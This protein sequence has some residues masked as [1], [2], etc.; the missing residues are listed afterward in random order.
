MRRQ[1]TRP[2]PHVEYVVAGA[3]PGKCREDLR[4]RLGVPAHEARVGIRR[5]EKTHQQMVCRRLLQ[6]LPVEVELHHFSG[7]DE[8][9]DRR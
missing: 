1:R 5:D 2:T 3:H 7:T 6:E 8:R 9:H 4:K